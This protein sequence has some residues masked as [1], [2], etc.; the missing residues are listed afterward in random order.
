MKTKLAS[1]NTQT[2][3]HAQNYFPAKI[4]FLP[5]NSEPKKLIE[6]YINDQ[7]TISATADKN[8]KPN[9][10]IHWLG[11]PDSSFGI[12][13]VRELQS[14][15]AYG[16]STNEEWWYVIQNGN[17]ITLPAQHALLK[18]LEEPPAQVHL[19]IASYQPANL[20]P[21]ILS[22]CISINLDAGRDLQ[23]QDTGAEKSYYQKILKLSLNDLIEFSADFTKREEAKPLF[24]SLIFE[25]HSL[26]QQQPGSKTINK[27]LNF[28]NQGYKLLATNVNVRLLVE[29]TLFKIYQT[30]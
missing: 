20:L 22:R 1:Q 25:A 29:Q 23:Q 8:N 19:C 12:D 4:F 7:Q 27:H 24:E 21:T 17:D 15:L 3:K 9:Q 26:L 6:K 2:T 16:L 13:D 11:N 14:Q 30:K 28:L 10:K 5:L 18:V